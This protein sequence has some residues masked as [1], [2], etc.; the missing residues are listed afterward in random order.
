M[1]FDEFFQECLSMANTDRQK[2]IMWR[3]LN[4]YQDYYDE[5]DSPEQ[6]MEKEWG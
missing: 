4:L 2:E 5:G 3:C 1:N 6:A